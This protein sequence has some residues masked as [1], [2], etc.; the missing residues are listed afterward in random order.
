MI[1]QY[2]YTR[3]LNWKRVYDSFFSLCPSE[4]RAVGHAHFT[5]VQ[6]SE[7]PGGASTGAVVTGTVAIGKTACQPVRLA[8]CKRA[9]PLRHMN[10]KLDVQ[11]LSYS[12]VLET[13]SKMRPSI[14]C[15]QPTTHPFEITKKGRR[16][17]SYPEP[18][19]HLIYRICMKYTPRE[20]WCTI[21]TTCNRNAK[22]QNWYI[23]IVTSILFK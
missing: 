18:R 8:G 6:G 12:C 3:I 14:S 19:F 16:L 1:N 2:Y 15:S 9:R 17:S 7:S 10:Q 5:W 13:E 21:T 11:T 22:T 4:S 23:V 20:T